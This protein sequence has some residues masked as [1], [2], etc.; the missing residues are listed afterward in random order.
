MRWIFAVSM[1][2]W[3][4]LAPSAVLATCVA[5]RL[6]LDAASCPV[7]QNC[8]LT[9][10]LDGGAVS[11]ASAA[12][13]LSGNGLSCNQCI[14]GPAASG[15]SCF[16]NAATCAVT[17]ADLAPP[18]TAFG[19]G[20]IATIQGTCNQVGTVSVSLGSVSLGGTDG[21]PVP[22]ACGVGTTVECVGSETDLPLCGDVDG[23]DRVTSSDALTVLRVS[24]GL[25]VPVHCAPWGQTLESG[26]AVCRDASDSE[27][28]CAGTGQDGE[29]RDGLSRSF[30]DNGDGTVTDLIT[31]LM[32]EKLS[33]D[34]S[35]HDRDVTYTWQQA[36]ASKVAVLNSSAFAGHSDW[37][38]PNVNELLSLVAY[39][40]T[41]P[42]VD[43]FFNSSCTTSCMVTV[44]SCTKSAGYWSSTP[45]QSPAGSSW[46]VNFELGGAATALR[47]AAKAVRGVRT[48]F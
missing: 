10:R 26:Q 35:I 24:V 38:L 7:G 39:G 48:A 45:A 20:A 46:L 23:N 5:P 41:A 21:L 17:L 11:V 30:V 47:S 25:P 19:N 29:R 37:R 43:E 14:Q 34:G 18:I 2:M 3:S 16:L 33:D 40:Q 9:I 6:T 8:D 1:T 31:G 28:P 42:A 32:W 4:L 36:V 22:G 12:A 15:G 44:C 13:Q 27:T